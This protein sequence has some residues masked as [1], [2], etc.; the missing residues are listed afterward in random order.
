MQA[1]DASGRHHDRPCLDNDVPAGIQVF[2]NRAGALPVSIQDQLNGR[3]EFKD[4][5]FL[6]ADLVAQDAHDLQ[7][8]QV[9]DGVGSLA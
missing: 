9:L 2:E 5:D 3:A 6:V 4:L 7:T 1:A 8:G